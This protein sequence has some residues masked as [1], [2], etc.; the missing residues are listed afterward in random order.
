MSARMEQRLREIL[1]E[2]REGRASPHGDAS[3][4]ATQSTTTRR[5]EGTMGHDGPATRPPTPA[6]APSPT[7]SVATCSS[8]TAAW[9]SSSTAS[10]PPIIST[11]CCASATCLDVRWR[12]RRNCRCLAACPSR[13]T[14]RRARCSLSIS[15]RPGWLAARARTR[16]SWA[17]RS[18]SRTGS[19]SGS[20]SC[21][22]YQ[23]E[24]RLLAEVEALVR[25]SAAL[26]SYNGKSFDVPVLETR[27]QFN[28][29]APPFDGIS[30]VDML[31]PARRFWRG[32]GASPGAWPETDSCRLS[33]LE[34]TLFGVR[35][36][37]DVPGHE[38]PGRY[39]AFM[40]SGDASPLEPV[41]E[42]NRLDLISLAALTARAVRL[43]AG[44][45]ASSASARESLGAG[46]LLERADR[47]DDRRD[48]L[49]RCGR[50]G[51]ATS[52]DPTSAGRAPMRYARWPCGAAAT[53]GTIRP[54]RRGRRLRSIGVR[55]PGSGARRS[56]RWRSTSSIA[57]A[58]SIRR[59]GSR[60]CRW[61]S[62][63][64]PR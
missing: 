18:S 50:A 33:V 27:Y 15:R 62:A 4:P 12:R 11:A 43:L 58:T 5:R 25:G 35:R 59:A 10:I 64:A 22:G 45:P 19:A 9:R 28:R 3:T 30:H 17:A 13:S 8:A 57:R 49:P 1:R 32:V 55:R 46:R 61:P 42:H 14:A 16:F 52:A 44:A 7:R 53:A 23:H 21:P 2:R 39:F 36:I 41:L 6:S 31:H 24:R 51:A 29:L 63:W 34:R 56:R 38:I 60:S 37:G 40:R 47:L 54:P 26:V 48:L 20:T